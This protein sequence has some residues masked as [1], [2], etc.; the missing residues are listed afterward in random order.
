MCYNL[1]YI[2]NFNMKMHIQ[3]FS[4][5]L[6][7]IEIP[8]GACPELNIEISHFVRNYSERRVRNDRK[9]IS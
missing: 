2:S 1:D 8:H 9:K 5:N 4:V 3:Q 7:S 6:K